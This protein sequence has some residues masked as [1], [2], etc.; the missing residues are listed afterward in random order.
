MPRNHICGFSPV[1]IEVRCFCRVF[2]IVGGF[3][4]R[5]KTGGLREP[6]F[7]SRLASTR[8]SPESRNVSRLDVAKKTRLSIAKY[9]FPPNL[10]EPGGL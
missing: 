6:G 1:H 2:L 8:E 5:K 10:S 3:G 7:V 9:M 4:G